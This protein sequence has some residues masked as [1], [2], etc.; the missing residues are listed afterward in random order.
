MEASHIIL[1]ALAGPALAGSNLHLVFEMIWFALEKTLSDG[2]EVAGTAKSPS[3]CRKLLS[4]VLA[5]GFEE[6]P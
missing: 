6:F 1:P 4:H 2:A 5:L 3:K